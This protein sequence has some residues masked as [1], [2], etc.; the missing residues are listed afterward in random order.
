MRGKP[1]RAQKCSLPRLSHPVHPTVKYFS[2]TKYR[3]EKSYAVLQTAILAYKIV[4]YVRMLHKIMFQFWSFESNLH[5][6][7]L[8]YKNITTYKRNCNSNVQPYRVYSWNRKILRSVRYFDDLI[9][10]RSLYHLENF[11]TELKNKTIPPLNFL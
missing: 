10:R 4:F 11:I 6:K 7:K 1:P 5:E 3:L 9:L 8:V 2:T